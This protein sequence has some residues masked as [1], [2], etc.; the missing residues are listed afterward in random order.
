M[1]VAG[2]TTMRVISMHKVTPEMEAGVLPGPGL[3][4]GMGQLIGDMRRDGVFVDGDGLRPTATRV[5]LRFKGGKPNAAA[6]AATRAPTSW[7]RR[8]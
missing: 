8:S 5:R 4:K 1:Y 2:T 3:I 6:R 7:W